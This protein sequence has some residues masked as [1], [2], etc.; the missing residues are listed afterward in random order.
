MNGNL[1]PIGRYLSWTGLFL[2]LIG[3]VVPAPVDEEFGLINMPPRILTE[4]V[5][6]SPIGGPVSLSP[7]EERTFYAVI[8]DPDFGDTLYWRVFINYHRNNA[9]LDVQ[10]NQVS[11]TSTNATI[12][13]SFILDPDD[14]LFELQSGYH[15]I[16]SIELLVADRPFDSVGFEPQGRVLNADEGLTDSFVWPVFFEE[17][18]CD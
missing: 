2:L 11:V 16:H 7:C 3:C 10:V 15:N 18:D 5:N 9:P 8:T 1:S 12:S 14:D 4:R 13:I 17:G 6:P